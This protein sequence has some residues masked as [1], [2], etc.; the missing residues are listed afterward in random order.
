MIILGSG[1]ATDKDGKPSK[2]CGRAIAESCVLATYG[3]AHPLLNSPIPLACCAIKGRWGV[4]SRTGFSAG[5]AQSFTAGGCA[6]FEN[7]GDSVTPMAAL[8]P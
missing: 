3:T 2:A 4:E 8:M 1:I 7:G 6:A 5:T